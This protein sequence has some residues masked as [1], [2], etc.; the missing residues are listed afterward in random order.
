MPR[1]RTEPAAFAELAGRLIR[2]EQIIGFAKWAFGAFGVA[3]VTASLTLYV[4]FYTLEARVEELRA[5]VA[6][7]TAELRSIG[8]RMER[9]T[10]Q[11]EANREASLQLRDEL[12]RLRGE[13]Q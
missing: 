12:H 5:I 1:P 11:L 8:V 6:V 2:L 4:R 10:T 9:L 7:D 3:F 13:R